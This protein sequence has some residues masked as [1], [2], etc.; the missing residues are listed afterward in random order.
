MMALKEMIQDLFSLEFEVCSA[1]K[2][3]LN[4]YFMAFESDPGSS[5]LPLASIDSALNRLYAAASIKGAPT[6]QIFKWYRQM[7]G[8]FALD[9]YARPL[10]SQGVRPA[11]IAAACIRLADMIFADYRSARL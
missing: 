9:S 8:K 10:V 5:L 3:D 7:S 2:F 4:P 1:L 6:D 11:L